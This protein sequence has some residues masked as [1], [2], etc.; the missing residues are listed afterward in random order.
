LLFREQL[1]SPFRKIAIGFFGLSLAK[2]PLANGCFFTR[3]AFWSEV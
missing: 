3:S 1:D 2:R